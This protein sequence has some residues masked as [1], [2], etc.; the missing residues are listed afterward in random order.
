MRVLRADRLCAATPNAIVLQQFAN[1][2]NPAIHRV[3]TPQ[4][5]LR[6]TDNH[7]DIFIAAV[8]T[9]GTLTGTGEALRAALPNVQIIAVEP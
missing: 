1:L 9:G 5:I 2:A 8:G 4:E 3:T 7:V 6:D